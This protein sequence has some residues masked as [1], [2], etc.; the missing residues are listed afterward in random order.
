M[1]VHQLEGNR[2]AWLNY[3]SVRMAMEVESL[4]AAADNMD[5][6]TEIVLLRRL[7]TLEARMS[8]ME[9]M[10]GRILMAIGENIPE[11]PLSD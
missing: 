2:L 5:T 11:A 9:Q 7:A 3:L 1:H 8:N 10:L 6:Q 4:D